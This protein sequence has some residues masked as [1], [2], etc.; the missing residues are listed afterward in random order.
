MRP[1]DTFRAEQRAAF[2]DP[3]LTVYVNTHLLLP[4]GKNRQYHTPDS[5]IASYIW[6]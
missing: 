2:R 3:A 4:Y 5:L 6:K 1:R